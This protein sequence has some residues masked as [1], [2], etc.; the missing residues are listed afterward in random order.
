MA[1][2]PALPLFTDAYLG[3]TQHLTLEEHG[4]YLKLLM[5]A[6][7][8][9]RCAVPADD[10]RIATMLGIGVKKWLRMK[11]AI[12]EF[13]TERARESSPES[14]KEFVQKRLLKERKWIDEKQKQ[15]S[16]AGKRSARKKKETA[17][18]DDGTTEP[19]GSATKRPTKGQLTHTH[20]RESYNPPPSD[21]R[22]S[23]EKTVSLVVVG[24]A[25]LRERFWPDHPNFAAPT[26]TL[27]SQARG[28]LAAGATP[29]MIL[30]CVEKRMTAMAQTGEPPPTNLGFVRLSVESLAAKATAEEEG[31]DLPISPT[32]AARQ[33][34]AAR[35]RNYAKGVV[36]AWPENDTSWG[37]PPDSAEQMAAAGCARSQPLDIPPALDRRGDNG[38]DSGKRAKR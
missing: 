34:R 30:G 28:Y 18:T 36:V 29:D 12:V 1:D 20:I 33:Q 17:P 21:A 31:D 32:E 26:M 24:F 22:A 23:N 4:A 14:E 38:V 8:S 5:I 2:Y 7:R 15:R 37:K 11:P 19:T 6:W 27:E 3:D 16:K 10:K 25:E 13:F 35:V 9:P